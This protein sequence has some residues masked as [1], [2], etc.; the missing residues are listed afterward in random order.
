MNAAKNRSETS[1][2]P[3]P[4][5]S[6]RTAEFPAVAPTPPPPPLFAPKPLDQAD[7]RIGARLKIVGDP[8]REGVCK[9][10]GAHRVRVNLDSGESVVILRGQV[11]AV[12]EPAA[13]KSSRKAGPKQLKLS[14][15]ASV[16]ALAQAIAGWDIPRERLIESLR[17]ALA[18]LELEN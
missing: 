4:S 11:L 16:A 7:V 6:R 18:K 5:K 13:P 17:Q 9:A 1:R 2:K 8:P 15:D 12:L 14:P 10:T 3:R